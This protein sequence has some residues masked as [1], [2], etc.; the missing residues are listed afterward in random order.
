M[1]SLIIKFSGFEGIVQFDAT[2]TG[3]YQREII[4]FVSPRGTAL[5]S[6]HL[7]NRVRPSWGGWLPPITGMLF[8]IKKKMSVLEYENPKI[9]AA[10]GAGT[11]SKLHFVN[12]IL[13]YFPTL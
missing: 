9:F 12:L 3:K 8:T 7:G 1:H 13:I 11:E 6:Q 2:M 4:G 5:G 10:L